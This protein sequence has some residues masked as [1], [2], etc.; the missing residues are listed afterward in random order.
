VADLFD[1]NPGHRT[2]AEWRELLTSLV[3]SL[4]QF[5]GI[6]F[7]PTSWYTS[8]DIPGHAS[9]SNCV[10]IRGVV[11]QVLRLDAC[12]VV[13]ISVNFGE[14]A[15]SSADLLLFSN[16]QRVVGPGK[17]MLLVYEQHGWASRGWVGDVYGEWEAHTTDKR[18]GIHE[19]GTSADGPST[20]S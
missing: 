17:L 19:Q 1:P 4:S 16:G 10:N 7:R 18:W 9:S 15:W 3:V 14:S 11:N 8:D 13:C 12:G 5:T 2:E 6:E 20:S